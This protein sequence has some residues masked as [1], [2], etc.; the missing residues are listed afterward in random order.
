MSA[1]PFT[2][3]GYTVQRRLGRGATGEVWQARVTSSGASVALKRI[4]VEDDD[5]RR[6]A[7]AEAA[8]LATLDHPNLIR[9]HSL[10]EADDA[11]VLVLDL[12]D[13]GSLAEL[14]AARGRLAPGETITAITPIAAA[15]AYLHDEGVVH[16]DISA[17]NILFSGDGV[18]LLAD[19][20]VARLL[21]DDAPA[22]AAAAYVDPTVAAGGVPGPASDVFML[23]AVALHALTGAPPWPGDATAALDAAR[24]GELDAVG[25]L[26]RAGVEPAM[27]AVLNR[28]LAP[29]PQRRGTA[30]ELALDLRHSAVP[31]AVDLDAGRPRRESAWTGPRHAATPRG[32][33]GPAGGA[34]GAASGDAARPAFERP[35]GLSTVGGAPPPTRMVG[36]RPRPVLARAAPRRWSWAPAWAAARSGSW[37]RAPLV[38]AVAVVAV[39]AVGGLVWARAGATAGP[40]AGPPTKGHRQVE[41]NPGRTRQSFRSTTTATRPARTARVA[42]RPT[43]TPVTDRWLAALRR[44]DV[45]RGEAFAR[46]DAALLRGVYQPGPLLVADTRLLGRLVPDGCALVGVHTRYT[47]AHVQSAGRQIILTVVATLAPSRLVCGERERAGAAG[48]GPTALRIELVR[49]AVGVR[50]AAQQREQAR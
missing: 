14:L 7:H 23:G 3:R 34:A 47:T 6:R 19:V 8:L 48:A 46:G 15:S 13:G 16:G 40:H 42:P 41:P 37:S 5:Q 29:D 20:G 4:A 35:H 32:A 26:L 50:I 36:L 44:L 43:P 49:T 22:A 31:V 27:V 12:A 45:V 28:A 25:R 10:I 38:V 9:L 39:L 33:A 24:V 18:A 1:S 17:A 30:A 2:L 21:G 11:L